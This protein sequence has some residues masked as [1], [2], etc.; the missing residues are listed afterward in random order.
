MFSFNFK[1][2]SFE[3]FSREVMRFSKLS[4]KG[5]EFERLSL[6]VFK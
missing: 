6:V 5:K 4:N 1:E 3:L 2:N